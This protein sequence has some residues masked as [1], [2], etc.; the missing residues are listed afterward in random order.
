LDLFYRF[1]FYSLSVRVV[2]RD[3]PGTWLIREPTAKVFDDNSVVQVDRQGANTF[4]KQPF[5]V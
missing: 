5:Q 2:P 4:D 3:D 1:G